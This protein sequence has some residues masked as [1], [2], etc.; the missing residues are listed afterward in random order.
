MSGLPFR[1]RAIEDACHARRCG[2]GPT[3]DLAGAP[4]ILGERRRPDGCRFGDFSESAM[5]FPQ[6]GRGQEVTTM[7]TCSHQW[8]NP[9]DPPISRLPYSPVIGPSRREMKPGTTYRCQRCGETLTVPR[10]IA[11][12]IAEVCDTCSYPVESDQHVKHCR[13]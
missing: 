5:P 7:P 10:R 3:S 12:V 6:T 2:F 1:N 11:G 8:I 9:E 4:P 13:S